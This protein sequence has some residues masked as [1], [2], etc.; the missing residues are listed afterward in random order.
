MGPAGGPRGSRAPS[1]PV[2][3]TFKQ[4]TFSTEQSDNDL[5]QSRIN[6]EPQSTKEDHSS[7]H[8]DRCDI[9][10]HAREGGVMTV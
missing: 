9:T 10:A 8:L 3:I 1:M 5:I 2:E 4:S 7:S 6:L